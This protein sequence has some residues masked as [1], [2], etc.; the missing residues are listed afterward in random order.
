VQTNQAARRTLDHLKNAVG[1]AV[2]P[3]GVG[4]QFTDFGV[5]AV[6]AGFF[7]LT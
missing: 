3:V 4:K 7:G 1:G 5:S 6:R 2:E